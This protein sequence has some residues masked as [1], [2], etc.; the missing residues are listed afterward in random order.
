ME[1]VRMLVPASGLWQ[2][3]GIL[4][5][6]AIPSL[7]T[8]TAWAQGMPVDGGS[9]S[10]G[11]QLL[12]WIGATALVVL[13]ARRMFSEQFHEQRTLRRLIKEVGGLLQR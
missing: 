7:L 8:Q 4:I 9:R 5:F 12:F 6:A 2:R 11:S 3:A 1:S 10:F 13:I